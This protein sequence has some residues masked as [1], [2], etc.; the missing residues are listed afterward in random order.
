M[1]LAIPLLITTLTTVPVVTTVDDLC[2]VV[3]RTTGTPTVCKP[4]AAGVPKYD[5]NVCCAGSV[6]FPESAGSCVGLES[7]YYCAL[8]ELTPTGEVDCYFEVPNY[9]DVHPCTTM[10][11]PPAW[12]DVTCCNQGICWPHQEGAGTCEPQDIYYCKDGVSNPD[13]TVTCFEFL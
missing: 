7:L 8:G 10:V 2:D 6:C 3:H 9:C 5:A 4:H 1:Y 12:E 11:S 13:G